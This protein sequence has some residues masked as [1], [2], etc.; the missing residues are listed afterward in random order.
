MTKLFRVLGMVCLACGI[1]AFFTLFLTQPLSGFMYGVFGIVLGLALYEI[2]E[3]RERL[4]HVER[5]LH[6]VEEEKKQ[7]QK[8]SCQGLVQE[9]KNKKI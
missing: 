8:N 5:T 2:G 4:H 3:L 6:I 1:V 7:K 9:G